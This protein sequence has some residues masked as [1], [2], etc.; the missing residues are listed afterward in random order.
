MIPW[1]REWAAWGVACI[2]SFI[3]KQASVLVPLICYQPRHRAPLERKVEALTF[4]SMSFPST[5]L[6]ISISALI[7]SHHCFLLA[8]TETT[9]IFLKWYNMCIKAQK[10]KPCSF[11]HSSATER[12]NTAGTTFNTHPVFTL[13]LFMTA[14]NVSS[15]GIWAQKLWSN[16]N[17]WSLIT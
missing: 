2:G 5:H 14:V 7:L 16:E 10:K 8:N 12:S 13:F 4:P 6:Q 1:T 17:L 3:T 15:H 11:K 9:Q